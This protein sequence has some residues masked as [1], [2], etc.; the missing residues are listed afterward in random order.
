[1]PSPRESQETSRCSSVCGESNAPTPRC[2]SKTIGENQGISLPNSLAPVQLPFELNSMSPKDQAS[3]LAVFEERDRNFMAARQLLMDHAM[4]AKEAETLANANGNKLTPQE[5]ELI[6]KK[7]D[8]MVE[9]IM[10]ELNTMEL[11]YEKIIQDLQ[12]KEMMSQLKI[13]LEAKCHDLRERL[14]QQGEPPLLRDLQHVLDNH[15]Q[16]VRELHN[17]ESIPANSETQ[18]PQ[19]EHQTPQSVD[20]SPRDENQTPRMKNHYII[21]S[22]EMS[23]HESAASFDASSAMSTPRAF[24]KEDEEKTA[25]RMMKQLKASLEKK[26]SKLLKNPS[27]KNG[28]ASIAQTKGSIP[29]ELSSGEMSCRLHFHPEMRMQD[30]EILDLCTDLNP[31]GKEPQTCEQPEVVKTQSPSDYERE[32]NLQIGLSA[33]DVELDQLAKDLHLAQAMATEEVFLDAPVMPKETLIHTNRG[34]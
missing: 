21:T 27:A 33:I 5:A 8:E 9:V 34:C 10:H 25:A 31:S 20:R 3:L 2:S 16:Q 11:G 32:L 17:R 18:T 30:A 22:N 26:R 12:A 6:A 23:D 7:H 29:V 14:A 19:N 28:V 1:M 4:A 15:L 24:L 13:S